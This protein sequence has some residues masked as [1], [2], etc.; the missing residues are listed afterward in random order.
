MGYNKQF[1]PYHRI[2]VLDT[3]TTSRFWNSAAPVQI[4][5]IIVDDRGNVL[6]KFNERIRTSHKIDPAASAVNHI[7]A[8]DLVNCRTEVPVLKDFIAWIISNKCDCLLSYNG[9]AFDLPMLNRRCQELGLSDCRI[10]DKNAA[11][12]LPH[13]DGRDTVLAA[14]KTNLFGIGTC[15]GRKWKLTLI[16][17]LLGIDSEGAHDAFVD[18]TRLKDVFFTLDPFVNPARWAIPSTEAQRPSAAHR[19]LI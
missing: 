5:A 10:F 18:I 9:R 3:E 6:D 14:K 12:A 7:Y 15:L 16:S 8:K 4:A 13:I 2:C 17:E 19:S 11:E 1:I